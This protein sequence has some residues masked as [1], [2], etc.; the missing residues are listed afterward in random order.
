L[1]GLEG[2]K[3]VEL[4]GYVA[5]PAC[6]RL[7]G[8]LGATIYKVEPP[9]GDDQRTQG[10]GWGFPNKT[11]FDDPTYDMSSMNK[12][13]I[14]VNLKSP[15]GRE[16][17]YKL[18][19]NSDILVTNYRDQALAKLGMDYET[20]HKMFPYVVWAQMRGY[21]ERGPEKDTKGFDATSYAARGGVLMSLPQ[22]G[23]HF[24]PANFPAGFGDWNASIVLT[25]GVLA[26]LV[27]KQRT[28][29]GDKVTA[30]LYHCACYAMTA[31]IMASQ[32]GTQ[33]PKSRKKASCPSNNSYKSKDGIW[34]L[35]CQP[36]Y[37]KYYDQLMALI[38]RESLIGDPRYCTLDAISR[39]NGI[40]E[41]VKIFENGFAEHDFSFWE[42][43]FQENDISYQKLFTCE[44]ILHDQE[45]YD[46]DILRKVT[47][48]NLGCYSVLTTPV[49]LK[50]VGDPEMRR[51]RPIGYDTRRIMLEHGYSSDEINRLYAA[52]SIRCYDGKPL[53]E[54]VLAPIFGPDMPAETMR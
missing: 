8:E 9:G 47:Y 15:E 52:G 4:A 53:P 43:T 49:R 23:E 11:E 16:F 28:G 45:A 1:R 51:S 48:E 26:A 12:E 22:A 14:S 7:L 27:R 41:V 46:N 37:D 31:A 25:T 42:K 32:Q 10:A 38:G 21:G 34:F 19:G 30:N 18:I 13:W 54:S 6:P 24:E 33:Y 29:M 40:A 2:I 44:D 3:V 17:L 50:S 20:I 35:V 39:D 5:G 36:H